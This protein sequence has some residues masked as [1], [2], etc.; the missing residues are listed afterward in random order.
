MV[1]APDG[2]VYVSGGF[3]TG[4]VFRVAPDGAVTAIASDLSDPAGIAL[5]SRGAL[6]V[7]ESGLHRILRIRAP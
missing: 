6:Y 2:T 5:D 7:A 4:Q 3:H 1:A